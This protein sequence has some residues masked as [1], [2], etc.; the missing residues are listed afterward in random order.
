MRTPAAILICTIAVV[1]TE[2]VPGEARL[3]QR[4][5]SFTIL[6]NGTVAEVTPVFGPIREVEWAPSWVP[7][8]LHPFE[9]AQREGAVFTTKS[10]NGRERLWMLTAYEPD[11]GR[12]EY[13]FVTPGLTFN[14]I[15]IRVVADGRR[16]CKAI[17]TYRHSALTS[18]GNEEVAKL[19]SRWAE[20]QRMHW[21]AA[22]NSL[23][24][25][26]DAHE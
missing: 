11:Q 10:T 4:T 7:H 13:V 20:Q 17:I 16:R 22:I 26:G 2:A 18:E 6:L 23:L 24:A 8:F 12:V 14:D 19:D 15:K 1:Q 25:K 21:E 5:Q 9:K 3:E